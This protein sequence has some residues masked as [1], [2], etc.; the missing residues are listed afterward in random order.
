MAIKFRKKTD[1]KRVSRFKNK[2]RIRKTI[3]G[4]TERPRLTVFK[5]SSHIYA[6]LID[7]SAGRTLL[8]CSTKEKSLAG[9]ANRKGAEAVGGSLAKRALEKNIENVVFDRN[10]YQYHGKIKNLADAAREAGLKF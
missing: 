2:M 7:D 10:G 1:T 6:Q 3:E 9:R 5:S 8:T 4:T